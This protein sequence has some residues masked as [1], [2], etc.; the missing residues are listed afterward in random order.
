[1]RLDKYLKTA[2]ILKRRSVSKELADQQRVYVNERIAKPSTE[3][4]EGDLIKVLFGNRELTV[5]VLQ[6]QKQ[7]NKNDAAL[8]FEVVEETIIHNPTLSES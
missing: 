1:M 8:M 4:K 2:R 5:R 3:V 6:L 7:A